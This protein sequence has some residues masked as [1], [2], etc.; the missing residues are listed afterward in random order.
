MENKTFAARVAQLS[1]Q[2]LEE[3]LIWCEGLFRSYANAFE[4]EAD[5]LK[6][7]GADAH[8]V[9][10]GRYSASASAY[11]HAAVVIRNIGENEY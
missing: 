2:E 10:V 8:P 1:R 3:H 9:N 6:K 4:L 11:R 5:R 7:L